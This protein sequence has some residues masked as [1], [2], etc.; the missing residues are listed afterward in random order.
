MSLKKVIRKFVNN[1]IESFINEIKYEIADDV[2]NLPVPNIMTVDETLDILVNEKKSICRF[3][4]GELGIINGEGIPFQ[5]FDAKLQKRL[6]DILSSDNDNVMIGLPRIAF[7]SMKNITEENK[8]FWRK[9][10]EY[11]RG[12]VLSYIDMNKQYCPTEVT[13]AYSY[14]ADYDMKK[15]FDKFR[16]IWDG[17]DV[18]IITGKTVFDKITH[19][20]FDNAKSVEYIYGPSKDAFSQYDDILDKAL[21]IDKN[22]IVISILGPTAKPL[23]YDLALEG[24][25]ALDLG[26]IAKSY[27]LYI[28]G[29]KTNDKNVNFYR[30]D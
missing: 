17:K 16:K 22:K 10:G 27:D 13:L 29:I 21:T 7:Y 25:Q 9:K 3:G 26:H 5:S 20:I 24:Y 19:N 11:F 12:I 1:Y 18:V 28:K 6:M 4:D 30:P 8:R 2:K 15:Y 23:S 14:Y